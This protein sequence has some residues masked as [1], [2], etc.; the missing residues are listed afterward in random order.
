M[1]IDLLKWN[2]NTNK[3]INLILELVTGEEI[4]A[5]PSKIVAGQE[6]EKTNQLLQSIGRALEQKLDTKE[7]VATIKNGS[8]EIKEKTSS[9]VVP[10]KTKP[11]E[12]VR[13]EKPATKEK[14]TVEKI[15]KPKEVKSKEPEKTTKPKVAKKVEKSLVKTKKPEIEVKEPE[16]EPEPEPIQIQEKPEKP[17]VIQKIE[18]EVNAIEVPP[19]KEEPPEIIPKPSTPKKE[20][21]IPIKR[22]NS[23]EELEAII[24]E[25]AERRRQEKIENRSAR[26]LEESK[27]ENKNVLEDQST[28]VIEKTKKLRRKKSEDNKENHNSPTIP[29]PAEET[30]KNPPNFIRQKTG[31]LPTTKPRTTLL[32]PPSVRP[33]S[34]RPGA[35]RRRDKNV[36]IILPPDETVQMGNISIK[37]ESFQSELE[38]DGEN[39]IIIEDP[40]DLSNEIFKTAAL[41]NAN[42]AEQG[43]LLKQILE[44]QKEFSV[45]G[46]DGSS[47]KNKADWD[48]PKRQSSAKQMDSLRESIQKLTRSVNPLGKLLDFLQED[49]DSMQRELSV[50][51]E[52]N[53]QTNLELNKERG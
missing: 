44:T 24:D 27:L 2:E 43:H 10:V 51:K 22:K 4:S 31:D 18:V 28:I 41:E 50:W 46:E 30:E 47:D 25:E 52:T 12:K 33:S 14:K 38:D 11:T 26:K 29:T 19:Q 17:E 16:P 6:P 13:A 15:I 39:L 21:K 45:G 53:R 20:S 40:V 35:P 34:A 8:S 9:K 48:D 1:I 36:E 23:A 5:R 42:E 7:A 32:R 37:V 3:K 49:I